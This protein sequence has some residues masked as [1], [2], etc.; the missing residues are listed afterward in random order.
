MPATLRI[1]VWG[2]SQLR[3]R[4][5]VCGY[6]QVRSFI[7]GTTFPFSLIEVRVVG[8]L[9]TKR[10]REG[11]LRAVLRQDIAFFDDVGA[12]E[13]ATRIQTDT[14]RYLCQLLALPFHH[15]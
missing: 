4:I 5:C 14:S 8:E 2:C 1:L 3:I 10:V 12:G 15:F 9:M 13:I 6:I 11:Y 7:V